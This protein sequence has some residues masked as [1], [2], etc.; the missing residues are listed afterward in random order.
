[1]SCLPLTA[2]FVAVDASATSASGTVDMG[3]IFPGV[4][5]L[6]TW[7]D[8]AYGEDGPSLSI[9]VS[10]DNV[11]S[12]GLVAPTTTGPVRQPSFNSAGFLVIVAEACP[13]RYVS[14]DVSAPSTGTV[15]VQVVPAG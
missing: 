3:A 7:T 14:I 1:M 5:V 4:A 15:T 2:P 8:G 11:N 12:A 6:A 13:A 10:Y 9:G